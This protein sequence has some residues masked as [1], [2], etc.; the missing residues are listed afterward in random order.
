M[1]MRLPR[2]LTVAAVLFGLCAVSEPVLAQSSLTRAQ[3]QTQTNADVPQN[4]AA[5]A[6]IPANVNNLLANIIASMG[7][8]T[9]PNNFTQPLQFSGLPNSGTIGL[10]ICAD[11]S[12][13]L[14]IRVSLNCFNTAGSGTVTSVAMTVPTGLS[15]GGS[16]VTGAGTLALTWS[17]GIP[18]SALA[19]STMTINGTV[20]T[21]G[22]SCAPSAAAALV[23]GSSAITGGTNGR[24]EFNN[25]GVL[26]E[27]SVSGSGNVALT[28]SPV[29]TT[30]NLGIPSF[31]TLTNATG[32]PL[33][34]GVT[35]NLPVGNL[36]GGTSAS[37]TTFW[38][39]DG[40]WA[41][42]AGGGGAT[43]TFGTHLTS[44]GS[45]YNGSGAVTITSD[46]TNA[47]T[48]S[49]IVARDGSGN[50]VA[51]TITAALT[52][53]AS[54]DL[55]LTGGTVTGATTFSN[56]NSYSGVSTW[57]GALIVPTRT[58]SAAGA[59]TVSATTDYFVCINKTTGAATTVNLPAS[60]AT[61]MTLLVADCKGDAA[62]NNITIAPAA[63][64]IDGSTSYVMNTNYQTVAVT[65]MGT[66]WKLN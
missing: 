48:V 6:I 28:T 38:R 42:P 18:N 53:H 51:G 64:N 32:L 31:L 15:V 40:T 23:V 16:P 54:L 5:G 11:S 29:F 3:L 17:G 49:T 30:P 60:P 22:G 10:S 27:Y 13:N 21:L 46:A 61:G 7:I 45:S 39:G 62:T 58:I 33:A 12:G 1:I 4:P 44:G 25:G 65:Y 20:C 19:N 50:F 47:N 26:G 8:L 57:S 36:N 2:L 43:L 56:N 24:V 37:S 63:G 66:F 41:T 59:V 34:T 55:P 14:I 35:G 52:G 9:S